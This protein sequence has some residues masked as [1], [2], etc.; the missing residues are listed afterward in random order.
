MTGI[1]STDPAVVRN[2]A[3]LKRTLETVQH[4]LNHQEQEDEDDS[5]LNVD[6][7]ADIELED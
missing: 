1:T 4:Q 6:T 5:D 2:D 3:V 7:F